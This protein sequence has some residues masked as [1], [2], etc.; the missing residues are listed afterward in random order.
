MC[1]KIKI[2][3]IS[4]LS[5]A[6]IFMGSCSNNDFDINS[7]NPNQPSSVPPSY[8]LSA[9]LAS[10][11]SRVLGG[12]ATFADF[13]MG[14]WAPYGEQS[15]TVLSYNLTSDTY[16]SNWDNTY[17]TLE[18]Y[19]FIEDQSTSAGMDY[20]RAIA[21][22]M[23]DFHFQ[24]LVD[25]YNN[26]PY[27]DA[28][29][30]TN[31]FPKYDSAVTIYRDLVVQL[32]SAVNIIKR[33]DALTAE[34]PGSNDVIFHGDMEQWIKFANTLKLKILM[35]Q[36][37]SPGGPAYIQSNLAGMSTDN[38]MGIGE[39]VGV[40]PGYSNSSREQQSPLWQ[41]V[42]YNT[43]GSP[44]G[45]YQ[46]TRANSFAVDFYLAT[47]D[48]LR[49]KQFYALN[50]DGIYRGRAFGS[51]DVGQGGNTISG[52]GS[53]ILQAPS[54]DAYILPAF[55]SLFIQAEAAQRGYI[56]GD[57]IELFKA[58]VTESFRIL[59]VPDYENAARELYSQSSDKVNID[60]ASN[61]IN[62]IILQKWAALNAYDPLESYCDWRRLGIPADL[63]VSVYPGTT[64]THIP[65]RLLYPTTEFHYNAANVNAQG[66]INQFTSK[67]FWMP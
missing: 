26:I 51:S 59:G 65:Y 6:I 20:F 5:A 22:I 21:K 32:D 63:P 18:N 56:S 23:K 47:N 58:G 49:I 43:D 44:N 50:S 45:G 35:R 4:I 67:I 36:T 34:S 62:T 48:T 3:K 19:K 33:A 25:M 7:P 31:N 30:A 10:S 12:D 60:V 8:V 41:N 15:P 13:W 46:Y 11:A 38:F 16:S 55:E 2:L 39:D 14:Y 53:G 54:M 42:G 17:I 64:A 66:N 27:S 37:Q 24:R 1:K 28:L 29:I 9:A 40:N 61:K 52:F 57:P